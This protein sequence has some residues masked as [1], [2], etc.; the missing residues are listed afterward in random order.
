M[1]FIFPLMLALMMC[2]SL[3]AEQPL[4]L[5]TCE[6]APF[7][8]ALLPGYGVSSQIVKEALKA[9]GRE[10]ILVFLPWRRAAAMTAQGRYA[11]SFPWAKNAER[12]ELFL[13]S[14]PIRVERIRFFARLD[15]ELDQAKS[16]Q[17]LRLC[18][19]DG[20]DT[21]SLQQQIVDLNLQLV[22]PNDMENCFRMLAADRVQLAALNQ[23]VAQSL[24][25]RLGDLGVPI[26]PVGAEVVADVSY[27]IVSR[28]FPDAEQLIADFNRGLALFKQ[29]GGYER[30]LEKS[31][32]R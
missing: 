18:I 15:R 7:T 16:W 21:A 32:R 22:R 29:S 9:V 2:G 31:A 6:F 17:G 8:G 11:G 10:T 24:L 4:V 25:L 19:P 3:R 27:F 13:Y 23:D 30:L 26:V 28:E 14:E 5:A 12:E 20:W 1:R